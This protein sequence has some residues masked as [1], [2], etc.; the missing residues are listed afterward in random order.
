MHMCYYY[1][2]K[3]LGCRYSVYMYYTGDLDYLTTHCNS[4]ICRKLRL[5]F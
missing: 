5:L 2:V 3:K 4:N 1:V